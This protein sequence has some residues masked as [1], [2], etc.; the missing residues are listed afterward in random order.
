M[1]AEAAREP[2]SAYE[3]SLAM[4]PRDLNISGRRF[5]LAETLA[6]VEHL[7]LLGQLYRTW[8]EAREVWLYHA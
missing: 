8:N 6:H 2:R 3:L 4:F 1:K 5:A 7:R